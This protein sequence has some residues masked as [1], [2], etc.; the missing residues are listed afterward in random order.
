MNF[1]YL[2]GMK[3]GLSYPPPWNLSGEGWIFYFLFPANGRSWKQRIGSIMLVNYHSSPVGPYKELLLMPGKIKVGQ[4]WVDR[5]TD[6][7]VDSDL[8]SNH[9]RKNWYIPKQ[10]GEFQWNTSDKKSFIAVKTGSQLLFSAELSPRPLRFPVNTNWFP[11]VLHQP[12]EE[13]NLWVNPYGEGR[14]RLTKVV[15]LYSDPEHFVDLEGARMLGAL[16]V[17]PFTLLFPVPDDA[18]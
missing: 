6:I 17:D 14:G 9:G 10:I 5:I 7:Y 18:P 16:K 3:P 12:G 13:K 8:S 11:I 15:D 2:E 4:K 1:T